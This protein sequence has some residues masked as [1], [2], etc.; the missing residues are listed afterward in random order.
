MC[1]DGNNGVDDDDD[2]MDARNLPKH[3]YLDVIS[4]LA[5]IHN[6]KRIYTETRS[7]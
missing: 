6:T 5:Q 4:P 1:D 3:I 7:S 2:D